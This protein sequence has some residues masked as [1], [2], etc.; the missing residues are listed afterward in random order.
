VVDQLSCN[1]AAKSK[2]TKLLSLEDDPVTLR[3]KIAKFAEYNKDLQKDLD[4]TEDE[5]QTL[6]TEI[7]TSRR[8]M[9]ESKIEAD[10]AIKAKTDIDIQLKHLI[11]VKKEQE[12]EIRQ[13]SNK[14]ADLEVALEAIDSAEVKW[15]KQKE[16]DI[17][18]FERQK[19]A[20]QIQ[21]RFLGRKLED[22]RR[23]LQ[24]KFFEAKQELK[25]NYRREVDQLKQRQDLQLSDFERDSKNDIT[26][27]KEKF[28]QK[29]KKLE[30]DNYN[31]RTKIESVIQ[32][33]NKQ[34]D[35]ITRLTK[36]LQRE[37]T[38]SEVMGTTS[39]EWMDQEQRE[40]FMNEFLTA[41]EKTLDR[42]TQQIRDKLIAAGE[43]LLLAKRR[44]AAAE[45]QVKES[46]H[47]LDEQSLLFR[48]LETSKNDIE[49]RLTKR[50]EQLEDQILRKNRHTEADYTL[51]QHKLQGHVDDK[52]E[53]LI[54]LKK[55]LDELHSKLKTHKVMANKMS[56]KVSDKLDIERVRFIQLE[57]EKHDL[58]SEGLHY[59]REIGDV[60]EQISSLEKEAARYKN[61]VSISSSELE[62]LQ[63]KNQTLEQ[64]LRRLESVPIKA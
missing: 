10:V 22:D 1:M 41:E 17:S 50:I 9:D 35:E 19:N 42:M 11:E 38:N 29:I 30:T 54:S 39:V 44:R 53:Q 4:S 5:L 58:A 15:S 47:D 2:Q 34:E 48:R 51:L 60:K 43:D 27:T 26:S 63:E 62:K 28:N 37:T 45:R 7:R 57:K 64:S 8:E 56:E 14:V 33:F 12:N 49:R 32:T 46:R 6:Q 13:L 52:D 40:T 36:C 25:R 24:S 18:E 59:N 16:K 21:S 20:I 61:Q 55:E 3:K 23:Q 31:M